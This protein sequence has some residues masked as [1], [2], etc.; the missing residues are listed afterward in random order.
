MF[1]TTVYQ[2]A[3]IDNLAQ[4]PPALVISSAIN[5][6]QFIFST[7]FVILLKLFIFAS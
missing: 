3:N 6:L 5:K 2:F 7:L 1:F 4:L